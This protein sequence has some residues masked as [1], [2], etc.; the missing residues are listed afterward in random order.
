MNKSNDMKS[1][2]EKYPKK[3]KNKTNKKNGDLKRRK[4]RL[5]RLG[6]KHLF[7]FFSNFLDIFF[8]L[9]CFFPLVSF[10]RAIWSTININTTLI[11]GLL[12]TTLLFRDKK[13]FKNRIKLKFDVQKYA[14]G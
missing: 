8:H 10:R 4:R 6:H 11:I 9:M 13:I 3:T 14:C 12:R 2:Q 7:G 1:E 5:Q